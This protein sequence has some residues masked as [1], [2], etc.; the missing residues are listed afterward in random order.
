MDILTVVKFLSLLF[1]IW[2]ILIYVG[3]LAYKRDIDWFF[4]FLTALST[5][6]FVWLQWL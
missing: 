5:T 3:L 2:C 6:I 4:I 1:S